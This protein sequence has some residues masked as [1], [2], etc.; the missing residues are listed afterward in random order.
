[1]PRVSIITA[2]Y[3]RSDVLRC[4]IASALAQT[5]ADFEHIVIGD[6]CTDDTADVVSGFSD[7]RLRFINR[8]EN[9]GEQSAPNNDG[10]AVSSGDIIAYLN[11]DDLW[12]P[13]HLERLVR[14]LDETGADLIYS[15]PFEIDRTG[16]PYCGASN[17]E[18][19][20]DPSH[21][22]VATF[23]AVRRRLIEELGGWRSAFDVHANS[24]SQDF[25]TRAWR[26][27]KDIRCHPQ[28][29]ALFLASGGR[30][31]SFVERDNSQHARLLAAMDDPAFRESL[32]TEC[33]MRTRRRV[34]ELEEPLRRSRLAA[35]LDRAA[36]LLKVRPDSMRNWMSGRSKGDHVNAIRA[37]GGLDPA[38][39]PR[40][41]PR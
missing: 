20:Y 30:P 23:W 7:P 36:I 14:S 4:A 25:L 27:G 16:A 21:L 29:T 13:D 32:L 33:A 26:R 28:V 6:A 39:P 15:L 37:F 34:S 10:F 12:F 18:L 9:C 17:E 41:K 35:A 2:T 31:N 19:R 11:H 22:V 8:L 24:P 5:F 40:K 1:M 38:T 3:N